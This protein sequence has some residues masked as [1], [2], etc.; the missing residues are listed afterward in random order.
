MG[1]GQRQSL[2]H[3]LTPPSEGLEFSVPRQASGDFE[4]RLRKGDLDTRRQTHPDFHLI[5]SH[6]LSRKV[7]GDNAA[8]LQPA[9]LAQQSQIPLRVLIYGWGS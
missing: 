8:Y 7:S 1:V 6:L 9:G 4:D 5:Y 2:P 3:L